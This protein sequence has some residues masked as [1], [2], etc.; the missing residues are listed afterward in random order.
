MNEPS[1]L[2]Y[3]KSKLMPWRGIKIEI[4]PMPETQAAAQAQETDAFLPE[5]NVRQK[6]ADVVERI[7]QVGTPVEAGLDSSAALSRTEIQEAVASPA[8]RSTS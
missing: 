5:E 6:P 7:Q 4:P 3:L 8:A 1:L 2:D